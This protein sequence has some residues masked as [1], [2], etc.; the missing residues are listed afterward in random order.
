MQEI[1]E[2][3]TKLRALGI[4]KKE[5]SYEYEQINIFRLDDSNQASSYQQPF[6][7]ALQTYINTIQFI[8]ETDRSLLAL[9]SDLVQIPPVIGQVIKA[10]KSTTSD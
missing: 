3:I 4:V 6:R 9:P 1:H 7:V 5:S 10:S 2:Y 8:N